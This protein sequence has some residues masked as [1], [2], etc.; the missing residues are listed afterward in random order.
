MTSHSTPRTHGL[1]VP[2]RTRAAGRPP[3]RASRRPRWRRC[4]PSPAPPRRTHSPTP[5]RSPPPPPRTATT[6]G[7]S[8]P[9]SRRSSTAPCAARSA[10]IPGVAL[11]VRL[12]GQRTWSGAAGKANLAPGGPDARGRPLPRR[13]H[14]EAV[15]R[16]RD[17]AAR[18]GGQ[19]RPRRS[20]PG[21]TARERTRA[22]P[23]GR[24]DHG[25]HAARPHQRAPRVRRRGLRP[26]GRGAPA[27]PLDRRRAPRPRGGDAAHRRRPASASP[28][29]TRTTTCSGCV[30]EH[31]TGKS[32]R[33]VVRERILDAAPPR[34]HLAA[35]AGHDPGAGATSPTATSASAARLYDF[36]ER[37]L[38]DGRRGRRE[39]AADDDRG[40]VALPA[41]GCSPA[42][43]SSTRE[44]A[45]GDAHV[46]AHAERP[47]PDRLRARPRA[48]R[49]P[50][51]RGG[52]RPHGHDGAGY[53]A[54]MFH[55]PAQNIDLSMVITS[56][57]DPSPVLFP[58]LKVLL[59]AAS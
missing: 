53:R 13:Q 38:L 51:R 56:P 33:T 22:L 14:R 10:G 49:A 31:A 36:T 16:R 2:P 9:A 20:A 42:G 7:P 27:P 25:A 21:G 24:R 12:P 46:P 28:T 41:R 26:R 50:R 18:R 23:R 1:G 34:A 54:F 47:R 57:A 55:L 40:P 29:P 30:I 45:R 6:P 19:V 5:R 15:R 17:A 35:R 4:S 8:A 3:R 39:C 11:Y 59:A 58:A 32:W 52:H 37:R 43:S 48:L 44:T